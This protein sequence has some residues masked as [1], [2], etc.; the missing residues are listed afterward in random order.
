MF[1]D[2][3]VALCNLMLQSL[4]VLAAPGSGQ[5][6]RVISSVA[7]PPPIYQPQPLVPPG[8]PRK[9]DGR[10]AFPPSVHRFV[11]THLGTEP[12]ALSVGGTVLTDN[13]RLIMLAHNFQH[14][15]LAGSQ[16]SNAR[17]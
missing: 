17:R 11:D 5:D 1:S 15:N 7:P 9:A 10:W 13:T 14:S 2:V 6:V 16:R 3:L 8:S 12:L 4:Q